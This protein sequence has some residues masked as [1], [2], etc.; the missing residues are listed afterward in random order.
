MSEIIDL[1]FDENV[2]VIKAGMKTPFSYKKKLESN[3][4]IITDS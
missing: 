2:P 4:E 3:S 1:D